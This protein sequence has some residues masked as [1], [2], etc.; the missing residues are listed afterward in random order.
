MEHIA[1]NMGEII[2]D[3]R[4]SKGR[5]QDALAQ[6]VGVSVQAVSKW[7]TGQ[8]MPDVSLLPAIA[9]FLGLTVDALFGREPAPQV[10]EEEKA[11]PPLFP[12]DGRLRVVQ[13]L[14]S[15]MMSAEECAGDRAIPLILEK[16]EGKLEVEVQGNAKISGSVNG[17]L[18]TAGS[19]A[20]EG[21]VNGS[22]SVS[23]DLLCK[24]NINGSVHPGKSFTQQGPEVSV[25][26]ESLSNSLSGLKSSLSG[27]G[28]MVSGMF[29]NR[30]TGNA[31]G[32]HMTAFFSG[33]LP[34]DDIIRVVQLQGRRVLSA[35]E[36]AG[37]QVIR[38][39]VDHMTNPLNVEI[40]GSAHIE[41]DIHGNATAGD[42]MACG[43][44][45]GSAQAGD[46]LTCGNVGGNATAGD[47]MTCGSV[48]GSATAG[49]SM[50]CGDVKGSVKAGDSARISGNVGGNVTASDSVT[51]GDIHGSVRADTVRYSGVKKASSGEK[52]VENSASAAAES[53][54]PDLSGFDSGALTVVQVMGGQIL[55]AEESRGK[56]AIRLNLE[57][58]EGI[59]VCIYGDA[60]IEGDVQGDV[61]ASGCVTCE[62][63]EGD[64]HAA[65]CATCET[66]EGDVTAGCAVTCGSVEGDVAAGS[67]VTCGSVEGNVTVQ[68]ASEDCS[69]K[70]ESVEG[71]VNALNATVE[72]GYVSGSVKALSGTPADCSIKCESV[73]GDVNALNATVECGYVSGSVDARSEHFPDC[74]VKCESVEGD[75]TAV[76]AVVEC[77]NVSGSVSAK[78]DGSCESSVVCAG[79]EGD[80]T[81]T[82]SFT[83][84]GCIG[85]DVY[86][87]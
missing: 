11:A 37:D 59:T 51:C 70:C 12:D 65:D 29:G 80:V 45:G 17:S 72:C 54:M 25:R 20:V 22:A 18:H 31:P 73:E 43:N 26:I 55:S 39:S 38:L 85:G 74:S 4:K 83:C 86:R 7:E 21:N 2:R 78:S 46:S 50:T 52:Q 13:F 47:G 23:G 41:G 79:V 66:V 35:E 30:R 10:N 28:N 24:G 32:A 82:G 14:G 49:D 15:R 60:Q 71:N 77:G 48:G 84:T 33:E 58:A 69:V 87:K 75:V 64:V 62:T 40:Y 68:G 81:V 67:A 63:V 76:N 56:R 57:D 44:V 9:D 42:G 3:T 5:T 1:W 61:Q 8:S 34:D 16:F 27:L 19:A 36:S 53:A 6:A